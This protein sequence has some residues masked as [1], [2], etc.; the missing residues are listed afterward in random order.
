MCN[1]LES[2]HE[3]WVVPEIF[4]GCC[5]AKSFPFDFFPG[6][7]P[8]DK[9]CL[10]RSIHTYSF[11]SFIPMLWLRRVHLFYKDVW[12]NSWGLK[13]RR[14]VRGDRVNG[15]IPWLS[16]NLRKI[17]LSFVKV[18]WCTSG[19]IYVYR[20]IES[21]SPKPNGCLDHQTR[22]ELI[23]S[24]TS[25]VP[26]LQMLRPQYNFGLPGEGCMLNRRDCSSFIQDT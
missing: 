21:Y 13:W 17:G 14:V 9:G 2:S 15:V 19:S 11:Y 12:E 6:V 4:L 23:Q 16:W 8:Y 5:F 7:F 1:I 22:L 24:N 3:F 25:A 26:T 18:G 10:F 20:I